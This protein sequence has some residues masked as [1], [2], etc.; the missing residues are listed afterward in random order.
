MMF[1]RTNTY[2]AAYRPF[3]KAN[4]EQPV[5]WMRASSMEEVLREADVI[6]LHPVLD[7]MAYHLINPGAWKTIATHVA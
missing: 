7:K 2:G 5:T 4:G 1:I 6:S 3:L